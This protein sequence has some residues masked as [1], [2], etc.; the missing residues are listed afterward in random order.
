M[1]RTARNVLGGPLATCSTNPMTGFWRDGCC[2]TGDE[3]LGVHTICA[4]VT[5]EFLSFSRRRGNDLST[6]APQHGFPG[7]KPG[8]QWCLCATR[9]R[10]AFEAGC[11]PDVVLEAT[12]EAAIDIVPIEALLRHATQ[13]EAMA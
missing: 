10:E 1:K 4:R 13:V 12:H 6:P 3:D 8:D 7:L 11:A 9:W 2:Q 5:A